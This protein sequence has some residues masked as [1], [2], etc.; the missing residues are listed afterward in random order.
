[1]A[2]NEI[3]MNFTTGNSRNRS[4]RRGASRK[5]MRE[6]LTPDD[7]GAAEGKNSVTKING[8][9]RA[10]SIFTLRATRLFL[11]ALT[12]IVFSSFQFIS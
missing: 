10:L 12:H 6:K 1:M 8:V 11:E 4:E 7:E 9:F 5:C 3:V 2:R